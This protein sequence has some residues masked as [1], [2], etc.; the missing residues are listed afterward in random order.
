MGAHVEDVRDVG[1]RGAL[2]E[3]VL[4]HAVRSNLTLVTADLDFADIRRYGASLGAG[5]VV[6]RLPGGATTRTILE[7]FRRFLAEKDLLEQLQGKLVIVEVDRIRV[8]RTVS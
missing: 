1:L 2:D 6:A 3:A 5:I 7:L 4:S 8:R